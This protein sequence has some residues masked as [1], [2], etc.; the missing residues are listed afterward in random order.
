M[1]RRLFRAVDELGGYF[2]ENGATLCDDG[3]LSSCHLRAEATLIS[4]AEIRK[5]AGITKIVLPDHLYPDQE[6]TKWGDPLL[7][8]GRRMRGELFGDESIQK[9]LSQGGVLHLY[10]KYVRHPRTYH[11]P[12]SPKVL[13]G[14]IEDDRAM[15][16]LAAFEGRRVIV[17]VKMDGSQATAYN[18]YLHG[19][20]ID[21]KSN[22]TW[23]WLQN[24]HRKF[25]HEIPEGY[26]VS[27][28]NLWGGVTQD[29]QY[30]HLQNY[31][32]AFMIWDDQNY[33]MSWDDS[34]EWF[35]LFSEVLKE[36]GDLRGMPHVPVLYD[37]CW[38]EDL[39]KGLFRPTY[40]GDPM[41]GFVVRLADR[42]HYKDFRYNV[43]KYVRAEQTV[44]HGGELR[45]NTTEGMNG[46]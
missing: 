2:L 3:T 29:I 41:E 26:R 21:F 40:N 38:D 37:G 30:R 13:I 45:K 7:G 12:F 14:D 10:T 31:A 39:I 20:T 44:R 32:S 22:V 34:V 27:L 16:S 15:S 5:A 35:E 28:E 42:F 9:I 46:G 24:F 18:D 25:A 8:D 19:R 4:C 33:C 11:L 6:Y 36:S 43:G 23:H 17:T 1:E